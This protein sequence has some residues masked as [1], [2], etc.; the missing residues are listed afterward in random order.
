[1]SKNIQCY[2]GNPGSNEDEE[3]GASPYKF[4]KHTKEIRLLVDRSP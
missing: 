4:D 2:M 1:M 3:H